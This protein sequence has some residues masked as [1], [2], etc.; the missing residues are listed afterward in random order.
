MN[1]LDN[2]VKLS[3]QAHK[4]TASQ[5]VTIVVLHGCVLRIYEQH[6]SDYIIFALV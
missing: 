1:I 6:M 5:I 3:Y 4:E 2:V